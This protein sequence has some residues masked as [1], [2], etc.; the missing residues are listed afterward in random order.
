MRTHVN[1]GSGLGWTRLS[2][3][4]ATTRMAAWISSAV[5]SYST[6]PISPRRARSGAGMLGGRVVTDDRWHSVI[7]AEGHWVIGVQLAPNHV[8]PGW[9]E[10]TPQQVH[11]DLHVD[12]P[13][14]AH[15]E[16][17]AARRASDAGRRSHRG[18]RAS[19]SCRPR[20]PPVLPRLGAPGRRSNPAVPAA[21]RRCN[22][23]HYRNVR[24]HTSPGAAEDAVGERAG[25]HR[26][27]VRASR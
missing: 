2:G 22:V 1:V 10:G 25:D 7:D 24:T 27:P 13:Q 19:G 14:R 4:S 6:P 21:V 11:L 12:D 9:P 17:V 5:W 18:R 15:A 3:G 16:A 20:R 23:S 8:P 26:Q